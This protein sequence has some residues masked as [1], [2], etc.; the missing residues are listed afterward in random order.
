MLHKRAAL[1]VLLCFFAGLLGGI[2]SSKTVAQA[3]TTPRVW[4][5][6]SFAWWMDTARSGRLHQGHPYA[7]AWRIDMG[8]RCGINC[9]AVQ[10]MGS[11]YLC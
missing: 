7:L 4:P 8:R 2:V 3:A 9:L 10:S 1:L 5:R 6:K 11:R